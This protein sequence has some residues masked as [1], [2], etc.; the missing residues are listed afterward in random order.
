MKRK[1]NILSLFLGVVILFTACEEDERPYDS[2]TGKEEI[3]LQIGQLVSN[4]FLPGD[5][6]GEYNIQI[7]VKAVGRVVGQVVTIPITIDSTSLVAG[8]I[9]ATEANVTINAGEN[10]GYANVTVN[11]DVVDL[12]VGYD[13]YYTLGTPSAYPMDENMNGVV[14]ILKVCPTALA[15]KYD[16]VSNGTNTDGIPPAVDHA[17]VVTIT[18]T[19]VFTYSIDRGFCGVLELWYCGPYGYCFDNPQDFADLC[20]V[21]S[22]TFGDSWG[23]TYPMDGTVDQATGVI[24]YHW[25]NAWGDEV[26]SVMT[27]Q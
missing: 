20:G 6:T 14:N 18:S 1:L 16:V 10:T 15:G 2:P 26:T 12:G 22:G 9:V 3:S 13:L 5:K 21:L 25:I 19:G 24:T 7:T 11:L 8:A 4:V 17:D 23:M 27:P